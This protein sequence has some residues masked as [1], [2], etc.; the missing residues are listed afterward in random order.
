VYHSA[1]GSANFYVN[2]S[3]VNTA[4][5][6][7]TSINTGT[8]ALQV[9]N[10]TYRG[11]YFPGYI[12][13]AGVWNTALNATDITN[14]YNSGNGQEYTAP[15]LTAH[16]LGNYFSIAPSGA[17]VT[18][19]ATTSF[20]Y[21]L[22]GNL[23]SAITAAT[24]TSYG[25]DYLNRLASSTVAGVGTTYG[26]DAFGNRVFQGTGTA[27]T[28]YPNQY[29]SVFSTISGAT[30][31]AT[32][33]EYLY[34][35]KTLL[36][37]M[38]QKL[39]NGTT[40]GTPITRYIQPDNLGSTA[41]TS[42]SN[43]NVAEW[44]DY[45]PYGSVIASENTGSTTAARQFIGQFSDASGLSYLNA[46]YYSP[47]QGQFLSEDP[48]FLALGNPV[49]L[50]Q[51]AGPNQGQLLMNPQSL[52]SYS[53]AQDNP[54]ALKDPFGLSYLQLAY[55]QANGTIFSTGG[56]RID[57]YGIE[58]FGGVG[59]G[60]GVERGVEG[61]AST[62]DLSHHPEVSNE[63][64]APYAEGWGETGS[65]V[66]SKTPYCSDCTANVSTEAGF[67]LGA[68]ASAGTVLEYSQPL[69]TWGSPP[70]DYNTLAY[71]SSYAYLSSQHA[72]I[73]SY[74][75]QTSSNTGHQ[76]SSQPTNSGGIS[77]AA[78]NSI[79]AALTQISVLLSK[80]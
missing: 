14:L 68:G 73:S 67:V 40:T 16:W 43:G 30:T 76:G 38:D 25:Y 10:D 22:D 13:A 58:Y 53:Y 27:T 72:T 36:A 23:I 26:Y 31:T 60:V 69:I 47:T 78:L 42:D 70:P 55:T 35:G 11:N 1:A 9:G 66:T 33:T 21:D 18:N 61:E 74:Q 77:S 62:G 63:N 54:I 8:Q 3:K 79:K 71:E 41:V 4:T 17:V 65:I 50:G 28:T 15:S 64:S 2:G 46:R 75:P 48:T 44:L 12:D 34:D 19:S 80:L 7:S 29:Y 37:T 51:L 6:I 52:N 57:Q 24:T 32:S 20:S 45:A 5:G 39:I 59:T 56:I 49:Q